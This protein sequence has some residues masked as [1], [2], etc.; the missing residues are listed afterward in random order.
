MHGTLIE[1]GSDTRKR[2]LIAGGGVA[3]LEALIALRRT[4]PEFVDVTLLAPRRE[5]TYR[6][7]SVAEPFGLVEPYRLDLAQAASDHGAHFVPGALKSFDSRRRIAVLEDGQRIGFDYLLLAIGTTASEA[8]AGAFTFRGPVDVPAY[9][10]LLDDLEAG[11]LRRVAFAVPS[12]QRWTLPLYELALMTAAHA[13]GRGIEAEIELVTAEKRPLEIFGARVSDHVTALLADAGIAL[14]T[15][16]TPLAVNRNR[17]ILAPSGSVTADRVV[18]LPNH[19]VPAIGG[20]P[21]EPGGFVPVDS[22]GRVRG[23]DH[24]YAA[25]DLTW[26]PV[27]QG[28]LA[29]QQADAAA[30]AIAAAAGATVV[31]QP[32]EPVLRG[33]LLTGGAP[34]YLHGENGVPGETDENALWWPPAKVAARYVGPY[35]AGTT[36]G[37]ALHDKHTDHHPALELAL[38]AADAAAGWDDFDGALRWLAAAERINLVLPGEYADKRARWRDLA[39]V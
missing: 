6:A 28:G 1:G 18:A 14:R 29:T 7:L 16:Q 32:F 35:L 21:R 25:G 34:E 3:A 31:P 26:H 37:V 30:S 27:K 5:L 4:A 19:R 24:V 10:E 17:I 22:F 11:R 23:L 13:A 12:G 33:V 2:V 20:L 15:G 36:P 38:E 9:K 39:A 8:L